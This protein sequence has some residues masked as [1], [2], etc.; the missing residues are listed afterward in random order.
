MPIRCFAT[1]PVLLALSGLTSAA[2]DGESRAVLST[3][4]RLF[5]AMAARDA[6]AARSVLLPGGSIVQV[7]EGAD[8]PSISAQSEFPDR[9]AAA[10][11][12]LRERIW[13]AKVLVHGRI[14]Q[15]WAPY[16]LHRGD[17]FSHCGVDAV[18]LVKTA[19][20]WKIAGLTYTVEKTGCKPPPK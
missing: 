15:V 12:P 6:A 14:A 10:N 13:D 17:T 1:L 16:D 4:E 7:R 19:E 11:A 18:T 8:A 2:A 5:E 20:G 9:I 3:V